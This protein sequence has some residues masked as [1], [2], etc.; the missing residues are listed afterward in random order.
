MSTQLQAVLRGPN[1]PYQ[2][3]NRIESIISAGALRWPDRMAVCGADGRGLTYAG[4]LDNACQFA[5]SLRA[6]R[7]DASIVAFRE[8]CSVDLITR[9]L[10]VM[11][12][13]KT[14]MALPPDWPEARVQSYLEK[15]NAELATSFDAVIHDPSCRAGKAIP[16]LDSIDMSKV[17]CVFLTS[18]ST[19]EP[20]L[21]AAPHLGVIRTSWDLE[22]F[23]EAG[24]FLQLSSPSWDVF[25]MEVWVTL[26]RGGT[27]SIGSMATLTGH[28]LRLWI[29]RGVSDLALPTTLFD[30]LATDDPGAFEGLSNLFVGGDRLSEASVERV[31][32]VNRSVRV[33]NA[34]GPVENTINTTLWPVP[35]NAVDGPY[36]LGHPVTNTGVAVVRGDLSVARR[37]EYGEI[38]IFG[39]GLSPGYVGSEARTHESFFT[40]QLGRG[41]VRVYKSGDMGRVRPDG[42]LDFLGRCDRQVKLRG[43]RLELGEVEQ[44]AE[45]LLGVGRVYAIG[46]PWGDGPKSQLAL[47]YSDT[48]TSPGWLK[49]QLES[50]LPPG[51]S[52]DIYHRVESLPVGRNGKVDLELVV[53]SMMESLSAKRHASTQDRSDEVHEF[54]RGLVPTVTDVIQ[55][56]MGFRLGLDV[57]IFS[58]GATSL[59]AMRIATLIE[60]RTGRKISPVE[61]LRCRSVKDIATRVSNG[62]RRSQRPAPR[63]TDPGL[64]FAPKVLPYVYGNFFAA[65]RA[66]REMDES[67]VPIVYSFDGAFSPAVLDRLTV[68]FNS[69]IGRHEALR[70]R[71]IN[72]SGGPRVEVWP[73]FKSH[74]RIQD[75]GSFRSEDEVIEGVR[76]WVYWAFDLGLVGPIRVGVAL[77]D[78][79]RKAVLVIAAHHLTF[80]GWSAKVFVDELKALMKGD[81]SARYVSA[82]WSFFDA[83]EKRHVFFRDALK[84]SIVDRRRRMDKSPE[85]RFPSS[86]GQLVWIGP[87][88]EIELE[89]GPDQAARLSG[90]TSRFGCTVT[91][92][93]LAAYVELLAELTGEGAPAIAIPVSG[94]GSPEELDT[95]GCM[96]DLTSIRV[97]VGDDRRQNLTNAASALSECL[98]PPIVPIGMIMGS[99]PS[100]CSRHPMLQAYF[101]QEELPCEVLR[102]DD[103]TGTRVRISP[104][105]AVPEISLEVWPYPASGGVLRY[106]T[107]AIQPCEAEM[108]SSRLIRLLEGYVNID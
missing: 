84:A 27:L 65:A 45:R 87:V 63:R 33:I 16:K 76:T 69:L 25:S 72:D 59:T 55:E 64:A 48:G 79:G 46:L 82:G 99:L 37:G 62:A 51:S 5:R 70:T 54:V 29:L 83:V 30:A 105:Q 94:R 91:A 6:N 39:D 88:H 12:A 52:P 108:L 3:Q 50:V 107:D 10:G 19:G 92:V 38:V 42:N 56:V 43:M 20:K 22:R 81:S 26:M 34:Y 58:H 102:I 104:R 100:G 17:Y 41:Q 7:A 85:L 66:G 96:A 53:D 71:L 60:V 95:I 67:V 31:Y 75:L 57:D 98:E 74:L 40:I 36:P 23:G 101:L 35:R 24:H 77:H 44:A 89:L 90:L 18:G 8:V 61:V 68:A 1:R 47:V 9:M 21:V 86:N 80:D 13:G 93:F 11:L 73:S 106:R 32:R 78:G 14:Y 15:A 4:L 103:L 97:R 28:Q 49:S 2:G